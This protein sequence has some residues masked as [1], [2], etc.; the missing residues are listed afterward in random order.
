MSKTAIGFIIIIV[1]VASLFALLFY[2]FTAMISCPAYWQGAHSR[3]NDLGCNGG[4]N[5]AWV[6]FLIF[7]ASLIALWITDRS[8]INNSERDDST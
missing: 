4:Q 3:A 1:I 2:L 7:F 5:G 6:S 8:S